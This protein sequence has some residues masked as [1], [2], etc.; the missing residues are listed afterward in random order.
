M[1]GDVN[2]A[3][4]TT[5]YEGRDIDE[6][7]SHLIN[8]NIQMV[9]DIREVPISRKRGFSKNVLRQRL[10]EYGVDYVHIRTLGSP[11]NLRKKLYQ[12][13]D[14]NHFF[15]NYEKHLEKCREELEELYEITK[16]K[17]SCLLCFEKN[18]SQCHRSS[19]ADRISKLNGTPIQIKHI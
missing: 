4:F 12:D 9:V 14:F 11:S 16:K 6:F 1:Q 7:L 18:P 5:G 19:V 15:E 10:A 17:I 13:K 8:N 3:I 2:S